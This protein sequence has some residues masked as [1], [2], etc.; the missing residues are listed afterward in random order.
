[1]KMA[2]FKG[3]NRQLMRAEASVRVGVLHLTPLHSNL[4]PLPS[5]TDEATFSIT[6]RHACALET[7]T[8]R[9]ED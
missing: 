8:N 6:V 1:M 9:G 2:S 4:G 7:G 3:T 5:W